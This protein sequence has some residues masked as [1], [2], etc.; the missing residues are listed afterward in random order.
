MHGK[1]NCR[2][3]ICIGR[4]VGREAEGVKEE[5]AKQGGPSRP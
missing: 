3:R 4:T 2:A 5:M 1:L